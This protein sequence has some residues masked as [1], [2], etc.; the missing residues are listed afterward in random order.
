MVV[1]TAWACGGSSEP[2]PPPATDGNIDN[3][4]PVSRPDPDGGSGP[5]GGTAPDDG[6]SGEPDGGG[7]EPDGG[8]SEPDG[9][10][11]EPDGGSGEPDGGSGSAESPWP[12]DAVTDFTARYGLSRVQAM[13]VDAAHNIWLLDGDR[14]GV[15]RA[16]TQQVV[17]TRSPIGQAQGGF[18]VDRAATGSTVI[19]GG[20]AGRAYVG[21]ATD[22]LRPDPEFP[23]LQP[24]YLVGPGEC[25]QPD[26]SKPCI[27]YSHRRLQYYKQGD[28]DVV[29]LNASGEVVLEEHLHQ[30]VR[31]RADGSVQT[32]PRVLADVHNL[33]IRNSNDHHFDEDRSILSCVTVMHGRDKGDV[34]VGSNH[35]VTRIRGLEYSSHRH[36]VWLNERGSQMAGY[37]YGLGIAQDGDVLMANDW[38]FGIVTPTPR[39]GDWDDMNKSVNLMKVE[40][41]YLPQLNSISEFDNWRGFQQ[42]TD[43]RYYLGSRDH[44]LW[45]MTI[46]WAANQAQTGERI[47][48]ANAEQNAALQ[49]INALAATGDGS[50]YI[51][52]DRAGLWRLTPMKTLEKV[53]SV[54]GS[55]VRQL[56]YDPRPTPAALYVL[57]DRGLT[58][59][60]G[61]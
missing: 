44:G 60:R 45:Q 53:E 28:V 4:P 22:D 13:G 19:C 31:N 35:G 23:D 25:Y 36:P 7:G 37:T 2:N 42:T 51:G 3:N 57:T 18:G 14:I 54:N 9:G 47:A 49:N 6:G 33:G 21:Y 56:L 39:H 34:Y 5:D 40:S 41:S 46:T 17:W 55:R 24:N 10:S 58:V 15:L 1:V 16:D 29:R 50:L 30:S 32:G 43:G 11:G 20:N 26:P 38:M 52:T 61:N 27:P 12:T 59:L 8:S 48:G